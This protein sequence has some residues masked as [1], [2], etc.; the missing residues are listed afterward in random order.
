MSLVV[1]SPGW[2]GGGRLSGF[3]VSVFGVW[4]SDFGMVF[5]CFIKLFRVYRV[6][7]IKL[8][9]LGPRSLVDGCTAVWIL[10]LRGSGERRV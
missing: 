10:S 2:G 9:G 5:V 7:A 3:G 8:H 4:G 6:T 1:R